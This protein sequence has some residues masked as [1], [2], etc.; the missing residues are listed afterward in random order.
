MI[1][2]PIIILLVCLVNLLCF[3]LLVS[4]TQTYLVENSTW[5]QNLTNI[6][7]GSIALGDIDN[8]GD[9]DLALLGQAISK[10]ISII[11]ENNGTS[12][13]ENSTWQQNLTGID[14]GSLMFGDIDNDGDLD[15]VLTGCNAG[16]DAVSSCTN[17]YDITKIYE[18]N[19]TSFRENSTWQQNLTAVYRSSLSFGDIDNDGDL[20]LVLTGISTSAGLIAKVYLNNGTSLIESTQWQQNLTKITESFLVLGDVN[21]DEKLDLILSGKDINSNKITKVYI[22]N[23]TSLT[24]SIQ[25]Y[26]NIHA[27]NEGSLVLGDFDSDSDLDLSLTGCC[28]HHRI[29]QN[30]GT[31]F[32]EIQVEGT[33]GGSLGAIL[34]GS[35]SLGDY[36]N[37]GDLDLIISGREQNT[38]LYLGYNNGT[39]SSAMNDP[40]SHIKNLD[41]SSVVWSDLDNDSDLDLI[42]TGYQSTTAHSLIYTNNL[43]NNPNEQST[44]PIQF[45]NYTTTDGNI[46]LGWGNGSDNETVSTGLYYNLKL[47]I[48]SNKNKIISGKYGGGEDN[49]YFGN[50]LQ[51]KNIT[52]KSDRLTT[53]TVYSWSVQ[54]ID[55][56][57]KAS[58]WSAEQNFTTLGDLTPP[59]ITLN[60][61]V[62]NYNTTYPYR[63]I[64]FNATV[65]DNINVTNVSLYGNWTGSFVINQTNS[66]GY[67]TSMSYL[68]NVNLSGYSDGYYIWGIKACDNSSLCTISSNRT[69]SIDTTYPRISLISPLNDSTSASSSVTFSYNVTDLHISNCSLIVNGQIKETDYSIQTDAAQ[70][71]STSLGNGAHNWNINCTDEVNHQN[72]S[73]INKLTVNYQP[74]TGGISRG[75]GKRASMQPSRIIESIP[76][77]ELKPIKPQDFREKLEKITAEQ[78]EKKEEP[79]KK[80]SLFEIIYG[81]IVSLFMVLGY[82]WIIKED[83]R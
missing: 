18:N 16:A 54:T 66:S 44:P 15:L 67:N 39:F 76:K 68:F 80:T 65:S 31:S 13:R 9:L 26:T 6:T 79:A 72:S 49:G 61:P 75:A 42:I 55:T 1:L 19:G 51:R 22:N 62:D 69:F 83:F 82:V 30:N 63:N 38:F 48:N 40:E 43:T 10:T 21:N 57:L 64:T 50:M 8:D 7:Q 52:I 56:G 27:V 37:D 34:E 70:E 77:P 71:I 41:W 58:S 24:E 23:G 20:D 33:A 36:D 46:H 2:K 73:A 60:A 3:S 17:G 74:S 81:F 25:W 45:T 28:D 14:Y 12:F 4:A 53:N 78:E 32:A 47:G 5:Y 29:Y 35:Q 59:T 11:Y